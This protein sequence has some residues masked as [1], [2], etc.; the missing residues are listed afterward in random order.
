VGYSANVNVARVGQR[1]APT[2]VSRGIISHTTRFDGPPATPTPTTN[3]PQTQSPAPAP[4]PAI[5]PAPV[6]R[7]P[8]GPIVRTMIVADRVVT[9]SGEGVMASEIAGLQQQAWVP[10]R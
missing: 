4:A 9:V 2:L 6:P 7:R 10:F 5:A 8:S 1:S 3:P